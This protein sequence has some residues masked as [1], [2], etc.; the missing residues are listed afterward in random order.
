MKLK[1]TLRSIAWITLL[2]LMSMIPIPIPFPKK[3]NLPKYL[4]EQ[5]DTNENEDEKDDIKELF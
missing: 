4:I 5:I 1:K 2:V 3:D